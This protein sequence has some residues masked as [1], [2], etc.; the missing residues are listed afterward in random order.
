MGAWRDRYRG[1]EKGLKVTGIDRAGHPFEYRV[2]PEVDASAKL[3]S[4]E[5]FGDI[6]ELKA[7]LI[8]NPRQL[9]RNLLGQLTLYATGT[10]V[11]FSDRPEIEFMLDQCEANGYR[12]RDLIHELVASNLFRGLPGQ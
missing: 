8:S 10:P 3:L 5:H 12:V 6:R 1:L 9:A 4:G 2:G 7:L 11:Q